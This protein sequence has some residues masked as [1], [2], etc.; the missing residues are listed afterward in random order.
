MHPGLETLAGT[1]GVPL[2]GVVERRIGQGVLFGMRIINN[3][4]VGAT[5]SHSSA[6]A[7]V[8]RQDALGKEGV[9]PADPVV[10]ERPRAVLLYSDVSDGSKSQQKPK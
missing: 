2:V 9:V 3:Q 8:V 10:H 4:Q 6:D 5:A 7:A 1:G